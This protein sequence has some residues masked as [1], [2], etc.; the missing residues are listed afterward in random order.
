MLLFASSA[1]HGSEDLDALLYGLQDGTPFTRFK[2]IEQIGD[3]ATPEAME[4]LVSLFTDEE[5]SHDR[6]HRDPITFPDA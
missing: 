6:Q 1:A 5:L 2:I 4:A 3:M